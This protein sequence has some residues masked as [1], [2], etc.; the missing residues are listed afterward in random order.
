MW[1]FELTGNH[2]GNQYIWCFQARL[3]KAS[4]GSCIVDLTLIRVSLSAG[5]T[6]A[7]FLRF[8]RDRVNRIFRSSWKHPDCSGS[9]RRTE[10]KKGIYV[11]STWE[12]IKAG[13]AKIISNNSTIG[14]KILLS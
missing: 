6:D 9:K 7:Y 10:Q 4:N 14:A 12:T 5:A 1:N 8:C 3:Q 13:P 2:V 11:F